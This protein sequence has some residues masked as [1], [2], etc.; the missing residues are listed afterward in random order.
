MAPGARWRFLALGGVLPRTAWGCYTGP[1]ARTP[2]ESAYRL[3]SHETKVVHRN[4]ASRHGAQENQA[5]A[6]L[7][8]AGLSSGITD[9]THFLLRDCSRHGF[10]VNVLLCGRLST[11]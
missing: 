3:R 7:N 2:H 6:Q 9:V 1:K 5:Y 10:H 4:P 11:A 8:A